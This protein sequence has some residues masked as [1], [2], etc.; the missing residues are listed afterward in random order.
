MMPGQLT[1]GEFVYGSTEKVED[2]GPRECVLVNGGS[3]DE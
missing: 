2:E 1:N 3:S